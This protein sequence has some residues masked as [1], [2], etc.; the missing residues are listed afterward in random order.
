MGLFEKTTK[1]VVDIKAKIGPK[2]R[3]DPKIKVELKIY[4][5]PILLVI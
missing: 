4:I 1:I 2:I 5:K 3:V